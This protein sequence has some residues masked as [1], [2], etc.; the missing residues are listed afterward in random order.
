[1]RSRAMCRHLDVRV[2]R[3]R[4]AAVTSGTVTADWHRERQGRRHRDRP[5]ESMM[6]QAPIGSCPNDPTLPQCPVIRAVVYSPVFFGLADPRKRSSAPARSSKVA[7]AAQYYACR[8]RISDQ[9]PYKAGGYEQMD[10]YHQCTVVLE[11]LDLYLSLSKWYNGMWY[12]MVD[13]WYYPLAYANVYRSL[14]YEC[15]S[16]SVNRWW[17][18]DFHA[19]AT[20]RGVMYA[21]YDSQQNQ[22]YCG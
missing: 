18:A 3:S 19:Y 7:R 1:M 11:D 8:M 14:R 9:S 5:V 13:R 10:V 15:Q 20:Y 21:A 22:D 12:R 17:K 6:E 4:R 2:L 16:Q